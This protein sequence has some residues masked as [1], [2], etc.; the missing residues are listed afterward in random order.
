MFTQLSQPLLYAEALLVYVVGLPQ[1]TFL[2]RLGRLNI[3][4]GNVDG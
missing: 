1:P 3:N 4:V 2:C